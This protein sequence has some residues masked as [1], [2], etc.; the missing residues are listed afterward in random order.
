MKTPIIIPALL[1]FGLHFGQGHN[2]LQ[3]K[4]TDF[5][6]TVHILESDIDKEYANV[7]SA[8]EEFHYV[9][10]IKIGKDKGVRLKTEVLDQHANPEYPLRITVR[11]NKGTNSWQ[12]P[13][14]LDNVKYMEAE[15]TLCLHDGS[16]EKQEEIA[17]VVS[18]SSLNKIQ[19]RLIL[20][21]VQDY[22]TKINQNKV[23]KNLGVASPV[24]HYVDLSNSMEKNLV[25]I[26][27]RSNDNVCGL[28]SVQPASCP[29]ADGSDT[30]RK[31]GS[32]WQ[33][34]LGLANFN[35][36]IRHDNFFIS[37]EKGFFIVFIALPSDQ[38]CG[39]QTLPTSS[40]SKTLTYTITNDISTKR[41]ALEAV[42]TA[43]VMAFICIGTFIIAYCYE[44]F[45]SKKN[46]KINP[47]TG[48]DEAMTVD[49]VDG[50]RVQRVAR[51]LP[52]YVHELA[53]KFDHDRLSSITA[54]AKA[55]FQKSDLYIWLVLMM[56]IFYGIPA[57]QLV[58]K[59]QDMLEISGNNDM[60]YYNFLCTLPLLNVRDFNHV[61]SNIG[62][63]FC[64]LTYIA[65]VWYRKKKYVAKLEALREAAQANPG[66]RLM[67]RGLPQH[68]GIYYA[69]GFALISEGVLSAIYH[70][71]P[72]NENFQFDT[73]FMYVIAVLSFIKI[74]QFR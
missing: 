30:I 22:R 55:I 19:Y 42:L 70:V 49:Q 62:Y 32:S 20:Y 26:Q 18:T 36:D 1:I 74:Y 51:Q 16:D 56:G 45:N 2:R 48:E 34:M 9:Y 44:N 43:L 47:V 64:G 67:P 15:R 71:C 27:V 35:V 39:N 41:I 24:F 29:I 63:M 38:E 59:Y 61:F 60:C 17:V 6:K 7:S 33:T 13:F 46:A 73:T 10:K 4:F 53:V 52:K 3:L 40:R 25:T 50:P 21:E 54:K 31:S 28:V 11:F 69:M 12:V 8:T 65:V 5:E 68:F 66:S 57:I 14:K 23:V 37:K 58:L 72:T